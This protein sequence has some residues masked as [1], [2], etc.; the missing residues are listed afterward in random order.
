MKINLALLVG[1]GPPSVKNFPEFCNPHG[2]DIWLAAAQAS[3]QVPNVRSAWAT[4]LWYYQEGC[5][6]SGLLP[7]VSQSS[8]DINLAARR[9]LQQRR[10]ALVRFVNRTNI[11]EG[12]KIWAASDS[13]QREGFGFILTSRFRLENHDP[14][15]DK[16]L[17]RLPFYRFGLLRQDK[18]WACRIDPALVFRITTHNR[19]SPRAW[20]A[21]YSIECPLHVDPRGMDFAQYV[22]TQLWNPLRSNRPFKGQILRRL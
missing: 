3:R 5:S 2:L 13:V 12:L 16:K 10:G 8:V 17:F 19:S 22:R 20:E 18:A 7:Y 14:Q 21:S 6:S 11:A 4:A 1:S 15:L 9:F